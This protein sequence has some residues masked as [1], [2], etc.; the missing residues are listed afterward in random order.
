MN[1]S[2]ITPSQYAKC[3]AIIHSAGAASGLVG[4]GLAQLPLSDSAVITPI[5]IG[6]TVAL[7][8]VF[9]VALTESAAEAPLVSAAAA[10]VGRAA[11]QVLVGWVPGIGNIVNC[12]T[13]LAITEGIGWLL[14][15]QFSNSVAFS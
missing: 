9:G 13:A 8:K 12:G 11:S 4:L 2:N 1:K 15:E 3:H 7:G 5:Q 10:M 14:V 6:M